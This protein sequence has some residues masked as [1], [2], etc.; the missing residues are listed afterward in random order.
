[1]QLWKKGTMFASLYYC[2]VSG[3]RGMFS[4]IL[5]YVFLFCAVDE[6]NRGLKQISDPEV[7]REM[8]MN[9]IKGNPK[10][11]EAY[12]GVSYPHLKLQL[13]SKH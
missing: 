12:K 4:L 11:H 5:T 2:C 10:E 9:V 8:I 3:E 1:M 7:I 13:K 6:T